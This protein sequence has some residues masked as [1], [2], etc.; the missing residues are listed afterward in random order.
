MKQTE[1]EL[2]YT[3]ELWP[4]DRQINRFL[5]SCLK[6]IAA[7]WNSECKRIDM[8]NNRLKVRISPKRETSFSEAKRVYENPSEKILKA[9]F[10]T[11]FKYFL[12]S[13]SVYS[14]ILF[15]KPIYHSFLFFHSFS[16]SGIIFRV[17]LI[18]THFNLL[19]PNQHFPFEPPKRN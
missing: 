15:L 12:L 14:N 18:S 3:Q 7:F 2:V 6:K 13:V 1:I 5:K 8:Q 9:F 4:K 10:S 19:D 17:S 11:I 16:L